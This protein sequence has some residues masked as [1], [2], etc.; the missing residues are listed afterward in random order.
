MSMRH[1]QYAYLLKESFWF[2]MEQ[3]KHYLPSLSMDSL[4]LTQFCCLS[5][6]K[7]VASRFLQMAILLYLEHLCST[8]TSV[9]TVL[10][11]GIMSLDPMALMMYQKILNNLF[12][13][14][15][16]ALLTCIH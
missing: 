14:L 13:R 6:D 10:K 16:S 15:Q 4:L 5:L 1:M 8:T 11:L 12:T 7:L 2:G 9:I 3:R